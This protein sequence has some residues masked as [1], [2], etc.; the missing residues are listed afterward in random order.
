MSL[1]FTIWFG[2]IAILLIILIF[3]AYVQRQ[4]GYFVRANIPGPPPTFLLGNLPPLWRAS[5]SFRQLETWTGLYGKIYGMFEGTL[6]IYV[7]SDVDFLEEVFIKKFDNFSSHK[8]VLGA[9]PRK[10]KRVHLFD[11]YG[12]R[13]RRQR[14]VI[15]PTFSKAKLTQMVPL[16]NGCIDELMKILAPFAD[17]K[18]LDI[19]IRPLYARMYMDAL[20]IVWLRDHIG[21]HV[22][23]ARKDKESNRVDLLR[24]MLDAAT[25]E[26]IP[27]D[28]DDNGEGIIESSELPTVTKQKLT[29]NE[30]IANAFLFFIGGTQ[31]T[32]STLSY[33]TF[34][35]ATHRDIQ[36]K[37]QDEI[38]ANTDDS[39]QLP[40]YDMIEKMEYLDI[41][42]KEVTRIYPVLPF[43]LNRLCTRDTTIGKHSIEK[44]ELIFQ[45]SGGNCTTS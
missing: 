38:D 39:S 13:W 28:E 35:L 37:V 22:L 34:I 19:D 9:L 26:A 36:Q 3:V 7:V 23:R 44:G 24:L 5:N 16:L 2:I 4:H 31:S 32:S 17:D 1:G 33:C 20:A 41:F 11:A 43:V 42:I 12:P 18:A 27:D 25:D 15:N 8:P 40:T 14:R 30:I 45:H 29:Y 10:D 6:P 21:E